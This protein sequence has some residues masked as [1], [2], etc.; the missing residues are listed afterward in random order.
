MDLRAVGALGRPTAGRAA[1]QRD[2]H[3]HTHSLTKRPQCARGGGCGGGAEFGVHVW[4][5]VEASGVP[6]ECA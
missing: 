5:C 2:K 4:Q 1:R 3:T 6:G